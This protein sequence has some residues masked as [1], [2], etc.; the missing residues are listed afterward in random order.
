MEEYWAAQPRLSRLLHELKIPLVEDITHSTLR[1]NSA[2]YPYQGDGDR[3][4]YL[5]GIF[6]DAERAT[7][8]KWN[9]NVELHAT[10][11][12]AHFAGRPL[13]AESRRFAPSALADFVQRSRFRARSV[14]GFA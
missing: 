2:T 12:A 11:A 5:R 6:S 7:F 13:D 3:D 8:M 10:T 9:E 4:K 1:L 14:N